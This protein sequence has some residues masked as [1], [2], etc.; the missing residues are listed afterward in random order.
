VLSIYHL[1][2]RIVRLILWGR[3]RRERKGGEARREKGLLLREKLE[4]KAKKGKGGKEGKTRG[5]GGAS[6]MN[7]LLR[8]CGDFIK[9]T[10]ML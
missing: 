5:G 9:L 8:L 2:V 4:G 10:N 1:H 7:S 3:E 6:T